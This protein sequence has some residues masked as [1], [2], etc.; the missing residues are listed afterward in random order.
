[1]ALYFNNLHFVRTKSGLLFVF[2]VFSGVR[3]GCPLSSVVFVLATDCINNYLSKRLGNGDRLCSYADD[4]AA[5]LRGYKRSLDRLI[6][7]LDV[8][9]S[10]SALVINESKCVCIPL[11]N[12]PLEN[13]K[14][15]VCSEFPGGSQYTFAWYAKYL[16]FYIGPGAM[17]REWKKIESS[18]IKIGLLVKNL[19]LPKLQ[20][21]ML[22]NMLAM[23][24]LMFPA[25]LRKPPLSLLCVVR[26]TQKKLCGG[27]MAWTPSNF[28]HYMNRDGGFPIDLKHCESLCKAVALRTF[29]AF[30]GQIVDANSIARSGKNGYNAHFVFPFPEWI[31]QCAFDFLSGLFGSWDENKFLDSVICKSLSISELCDRK[32]LQNRI[33]THIRDSNVPL[34]MVRALEERFKLRGWWSD[35]FLNGCAIAATKLILDLRGVVPPC[36]QFCFLKS[37]F[38]GWPTAARMQDRGNPNNRC[39][40]CS[41]CHGTD[42]LEHYGCCNFGWRFFAKKFNCSVFPMSLERFFGL[43]ART[44][45]MQVHH[46]IHVYAVYSLTN[47]RRYIN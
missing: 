13:I 4:A 25:Q 1:M 39:M 11:W 30:K 40:L 16:G 37:L 29:Y 7:A 27:G 10:I 21:F 43:N 47:L 20:A 35:A 18:I 34:S 26:E 42:S 44:F 9:G 19:G 46:V 31:S 12:E 14:S 33:Y 17:G 38:N 2:T 28:V 5:L 6:N 32:S 23:S 22:F 8:I 45:H 15:M 36:I 41:E 24:K 3:Q